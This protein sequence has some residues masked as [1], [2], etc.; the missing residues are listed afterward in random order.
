MSFLDP[1]LDLKN[2]PI[3]LEELTQAKNAAG[4]T[5]NTW[6]TKTSIFGWKWKNGAVGVSD[7]KL[8]AV[9]NGQI[10]IDPRD[11]NYTIDDDW[12]FVSGGYRHYISDVDNIG[13]QGEVIVITWDRREDQA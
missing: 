2:I 4:Q 12:R 6:T 9:S 11:I 13:E 1:F 5:V 3:V 8:L 10:A 7:G